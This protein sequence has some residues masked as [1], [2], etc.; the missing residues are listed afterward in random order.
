MVG[1]LLEM[2][3]KKFEAC[4]ERSEYI[5]EQLEQLNVQEMMH[6]QE[7]MLDNDLEMDEN[8][9][10]SSKCGKALENLF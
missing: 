5:F 3:K 2:A 6:L 8:G 1:T 10:V 9:G 7:D 4:V